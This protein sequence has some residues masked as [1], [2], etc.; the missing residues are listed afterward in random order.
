MVAGTANVTGLAQP[1]EVR[2]AQISD[3]VLDVLDVPPTAGRWLNAADQDPHGSKAV[4]LNDG[5]WQRR[6]GG[7]RSVIGRNIEID[8]QPRVIVGVMPRGFKVVYATSTF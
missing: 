7:D 3:G 6:F 8:S 4:M 2:T 1:E 5:Y